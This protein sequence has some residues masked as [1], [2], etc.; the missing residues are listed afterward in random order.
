MIVHFELYLLAVVGVLI[1]HAKTFVEYDK[2]GKKYEVRKFVPT[3]LLSLLT[4][5]VLVYLR[6]DIESLYVITPFSALIIGYFGNSVLFS[7]IKA[8][9]PD[10][11]A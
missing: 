11:D 1:H 5:T 9:K 6:K 2:Q 4:S 10:L 7:F 3:I 8:K